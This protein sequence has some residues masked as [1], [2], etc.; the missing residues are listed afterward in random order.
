MS[1]TERGLETKRCGWNLFSYQKSASRHVRL[2]SVRY[3]LGFDLGLTHSLFCMAFKAYLKGMANHTY[4]KIQGMP[5]TLSLRSTGVEAMEKL[6]AYFTTNTFEF[7]LEYDSKK[8]FT[9]QFDDSLTVCTFHAAETVRAAFE[10]WINSAGFESQKF[11]RFAWNIHL[12]IGGGMYG[13]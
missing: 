3:R 10:A 9:L 2:P 6:R 7:D 5:Y 11:S 8:K 1:Q 13:M 12:L 4:P